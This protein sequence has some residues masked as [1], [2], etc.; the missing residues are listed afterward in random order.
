MSAIIGGGIVGIPFSMIHTG[1]PLGSILILCIAAVSVNAG[2]LYLHCKDLSPTN[3]ESLYEL[4]FVTMGKYSI[5]VISSLTVVNYTGG[6][7]IYFLVF[8]D[9]SASFAKQY[10][11]ENEDNIWT[12]N[13]IYI[14]SLAVVM[15]PFSLKK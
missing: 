7:M 9:I 4:A 1:I 10:Y 14:I 3:V 11:G 8:G 2:S 12:K 13:N 5:Y 6:I 15:V